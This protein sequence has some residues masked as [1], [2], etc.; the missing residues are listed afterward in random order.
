[1]RVEFIISFI[2]SFLVAGVA[3]AAGLEQRPGEQRPETLIR[4]DTELV[5]ID[6]VVEDEK[7]RLVRD[8][9]REDF[10][11]IEDGSAA[12]SQLFFGCDCR[13]GGTIADHDE[14]V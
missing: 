7:G 11:L 2:F 1:M 3:V 8:L 13:Q 12:V 4:L 9:R 10:Q 14:Q 6:V 5:Q